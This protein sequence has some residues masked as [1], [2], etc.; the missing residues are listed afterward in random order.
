MSLVISASGQPVNVSAENRSLL[1]HDLVVEG[2]EHPVRVVPAAP[3]RARRHRIA[4]PELGEALRAVAAGGPP[5][6]LVEAHDLGR[7]REVPGTILL[8]VGT[9]EGGEMEV[10]EL[11]AGRQVEDALIGDPRPVRLDDRPD[12][13][14]VR[15]ALRE[16]EALVALGAQPRLLLAHPVGVRRVDPR[17]PLVE[18]AVE[19]EAVLLGERPE[20][21]SDRPG[22]VVPVA[23]GKKEVGLIAHCRVSV[24]PADE[25]SR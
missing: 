11:L 21:S 2:E 24:V 5:L 4:E 16:G 23:A 19:A 22:H 25:S 14:A 17:D 9:G 13:L 12:P 8:L 1:L 15:F 18:L 20:E 7:G 10:L 6:L 3:G